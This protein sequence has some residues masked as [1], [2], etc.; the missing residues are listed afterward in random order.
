MTPKF[1]IDVSEFQGHIDWERVCKEVDFA[2]LRA[3][4]GSGNVDECFHENAKGCTRTGVPFGA[5]WFSYA[6]TEE[7][8]R[9]E[10]DYIC[11]LVS[12]YMPTYPICFD[13]EYDSLEYAHDNG[14]PITKEKLCNIATAFLTRV[15]ERGYYAMN[16]TNLDFLDLGFSKLCD[17]FDTWVAAWSYEERPISCG[18]FQFSSSF[19]VDGIEGFVDADYA[20][21]DYPKIIA[22]MDEPVEPEIPKDHSQEL[23]KIYADTITRYLQLAGEIILGKYGDGDERKQAILAMGYDY[24]FVQEIVTALLS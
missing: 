15:E 18:I 16:Y 9:K 7:M 13:F 2:I 17:R 8:A 19:V 4:Y 11:D 20:Y 22:D 21:K 3:G 5:Y 12:H 24:E 10:A 14:I 1:G 23:K 6:Y